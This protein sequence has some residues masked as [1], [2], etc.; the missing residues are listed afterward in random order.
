MERCLA[1]FEWGDE[2]L[3]SMKGM[4]NTK[5]KY[6]LKNCAWR[7]DVDERVGGVAKAMCIKRA[8]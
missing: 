6:M 2:R 5:V 3:D 4:S 8:G 7:E 1:N